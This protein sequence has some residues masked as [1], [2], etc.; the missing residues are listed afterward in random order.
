MSV[1]LLKKSNIMDTRTLPPS[2]KCG[3]RVAIH[4]E[5]GRLS[6][7]DDALEYAC[8]FLS[9]IRGA[10]QVFVAHMSGALEEKIARLQ[11]E[12]AS[13]NEFRLRDATFKRELELY[14]ESL[15]KGRV[16]AEKAGKESLFEVRVAQLDVG[17]TVDDTVKGAALFDALDKFDP[18]PAEVKQSIQ[19]DDVIGFNLCVNATRVRVGVRDFSDLVWVDQL[20]GAGTV[21][22]AEQVATGPYLTYKA[23]T[24]GTT[25]LMVPKT[26]TPLKLYH[27][28]RVKAQTVDIMFGQM[29]MPALRDVSAAVDRFTPPNSN[30]SP[31]LPWWDKLR[32]MVHGVFEVAVSDFTIRFV[33]SRTQRDLLEYLFVKAKTLDGTLGR[34]KVDLRATAVELHERPVPDEKRPP[35]FE[36][37]KLH[38]C[39]SLGWQCKSSPYNHYVFS[40][41]QSHAAPSPTQDCFAAFRSKSLEMGLTI[42]LEPADDAD[43][44]CTFALSS[45]HT[46]LDGFKRALVSQPHCH[47]GQKM[48]VR[49]GIPTKEPF[50]S[51]A[52][53]GDLISSLDL[54]LNA[55]APQVC[56]F[57]QYGGQHGVHARIEVLAWNIKLNHEKSFFPRR[58]DSAVLLPPRPDM[59][60]TMISTAL[61]VHSVILERVPPEF[62]DDQA[63]RVELK[64]LADVKSIG[65]KIDPDSTPRSGVTV[66]QLRILVNADMMLALYEWMDALGTMNPPDVWTLDRAPPAPEEAVL[67]QSAKSDRDAHRFFVE[68][69]D[70]H[71]SFQS[72]ESATMLTNTMTRLDRF[73]D[74]G[75][76][77]YLFVVADLGGFAGTVIGEQ[78]AWLQDDGQLQQILMPCLLRLDYSVNKAF[79]LEQDSIGGHKPQTKISVDIPDLLFRSHM[80]AFWSVLEVVNHC[81][82]VTRK[83]KLDVDQKGFLYS[84]Q[85]SSETLTLLNCWR[86]R[87]RLLQ[88][89][90]MVVRSEKASFKAVPVEERPDLTILR[91][92][93][94]RLEKLRLLA[95]QD[96]I[97]SYLFEKQQHTQKVQGAGRPHREIDVHVDKITWILEAVK[98]D[99]RR[100]DIA[101]AKLL[102]FGAAVITDTNMSS[103][104]WLEMRS[105]RIVN[106]QTVDLQWRNA[107]EPV[108]AVEDV[109]AA[110][111]YF[112]R[113]A[114]VGGIPIYDHFEFTMMPLT[115]RFTSDL[116]DSLHAFLLPDSDETAKNAAAI[117]QSN[118]LSPQR[119]VYEIK[120]EP[121]PIDETR[122]A[123]IVKHRRTRSLVTPPTISK[124]QRREM[125]AHL[126]AIEKREA[127]ARWNLSFLFVQINQVD[128]SVSWNGSPRT[129]VD[130]PLQVHR[131]QF[132]G[133]TYAWRDLFEDF[134]QKM[135]GDLI[136]QVAGGVARGVFGRKFRAAVDSPARTPSEADRATAREQ[137]L[138]EKRLENARKL[139]GTPY[140]DH[141][142]QLQ[143]PPVRTEP[144][145]VDENW[146]Y[147][148]LVLEDRIVFVLPRDRSSGHS[149]FDNR[150]S[151]SSDGS[152][153]SSKSSFDDCVSVS[154]FSSL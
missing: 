30:P 66:Q 127:R 74:F 82:L 150:V 80:T 132:T 120:T 151:V 143:P 87:L 99:G 77:K 60:W 64:F 93:L 112:K 78:P 2:G 103:K 102:R 110:Q 146:T 79:S 115:I 111:L 4:V 118:M 65:V 47:D 105:A 152:F 75:K 95:A 94:L 50:R 134:K 28:L 34:G 61:N 32:F 3:V 49:A 142:A 10:H 72:E 19:Y 25:E 148:G 125:S 137:L 45:F 22:L 43:P 20:E 107:L 6:F 41:G 51:K 122:V 46:M 9:Y 54:T 17:I 36:I 121:L 76:S 84:E 23:V 7:E 15:E 124:P 21:L 130:M 145:F 140:T 39:L 108:E 27:N 113:S 101:A 136:G 81:I 57:Q 91:L 26:L 104:V 126:L 123:T 40:N 48:A 8:R 129:I 144:V 128:L 37:P 83:S 109:Y 16:R 116:Y 135:K 147:E 33:S 62:F 70:T 1:G 31:S 90:S 69:Y 106:E 92:Q 63:S 149:S 117:V 68:F 73:D 100:F 44:T 141:R 42:D 71:I 13:F 11:Q 86:E 38:V 14:M 29:Y 58:G 133:K 67:P 153:V 97:S 52:D 114:A 85:F 5:S 12:V 24:V 89:R 59:D 53:F 138:G 131:I 96:R 139:L 154:S 35:L 55:C 119:Q 56:I 18:A 88:E 98:P